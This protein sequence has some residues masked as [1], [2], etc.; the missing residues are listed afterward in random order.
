MSFYKEV[1]GRKTT[2]EST[3]KFDTTPTAGST[4]PVTS[5]GVKTAIDGAVGYAAENLQD[6]IDEIAEKAGSGYTPKGEASVATLNALSGQENGELYTMTDA[7]TLTEGSLAVVAGDTVAWDATNEV[8]YKAMD[9]APMQYGTNEVHN[10]PT[11]ITAF[12]TGDVIPVDGPSGT[13]KMSKDD[14]LRVTAENALGSIHSL[15]DAA[16]EADLVSGNYLALDGDGGTK[17]LPADIVPACKI[18]DRGSATIATIN[19]LAFKQDGW[20]FVVSDSGTLSAG[21]LDVTAGDSVVWNATA[22]AWF[23]LFQYA[24][25]QVELL[26]NRSVK[27]SRGVTINKDVYYL[28][29]IDGKYG[30]NSGGLSDNHEYISYIYDVI[31]DTDIYCSTSNVVY[32]SLSI[33]NKEMT[34]G[35]RYRRY[36]DDSED[37]LPT[38]NSPASVKAGQRIIV[39]V[40]KNRNF[41]WAFTMPDEIFVSSLNDELKR[42]VN[43]EVVDYVKGL[44]LDENCRF[45]TFVDKHYGDN[46][47]RLVAGNGY[48]S[49]IY[50]VPATTELYVTDSTPDYLSISVTNT[51]MTSGVRYRKYVDGGEDDLPTSGSPIIVDG[52]KRLIITVVRSDTSSWEFEL[53]DVIYQDHLQPIPLDD[54]QVQQVI[55]ASKYRI[56]V[57]YNSSASFQSTESVDVYVP[58]KVGF[59]HYSFGHCVDVGKNCDC[60]RVVIAYA[61]DEHLVK[62][63]D[64]T[65][66]GEWECALK[67]QGRPDFAGG[68]THGD[69]VIV[70]SPSFFIDGKQ[71]SLSDIS[72]ITECEEFRVVTK[73]SMY[74]PN[75]GTTLIAYHGCEHLFSKNGL[76]LRQ[77]ILWQGNFSL[78]ECYLA[79]NLVKKAVSTTYYTDADFDVNTIPNPLN[80]EIDNARFVAMIDDTNGVFN[81]FYIGKNYPE[82]DSDSGKLL[83]TDNGGNNYNK[84]YYIVCKNATSTSDELWKSE[85]FVDFKI[86]K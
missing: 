42:N 83:L 60:W 50:D 51:E 21:S 16:T 46:N 35:V 55:D 22:N 53:P 29:S 10:L 79:M 85:S 3:L 76:R 25:E 61:V 69:E 45:L 13:A 1:P 70:G 80:I 5:E 38:E 41:N 71:V 33:T 73:T 47:G 20:K 30:N 40:K 19:A 56:K 27:F 32:L 11:S 44:A 36:D 75:D 54:T 66:Q 67:L 81:E 15:S 48:K 59:C 39:S 2:L 31:A 77:D 62:R 7:G 18:V 28:Q 74:D 26:F 8:W 34:S 72:S 57:I 9:Y 68:Y 17:K 58:Q 14:L 84:G 4:N 64:L 12:R 43:E 52:G 63:Y 6:Q 65:H 24:R 23:L 82:I 86:G 49:W 37:T 78:R